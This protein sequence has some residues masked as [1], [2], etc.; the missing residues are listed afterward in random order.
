MSSIIL[1]GCLGSTFFLSWGSHFVLL[2]FF[3]YI[4]IKSPGITTALSHTESQK[5]ENRWYNFTPVLCRI[6]FCL[7][8]EQN[9]TERVLKVYPWHKLLCITNNIWLT[10]KS[11]ILSM[12]SHFFSQFVKILSINYLNLKYEEK[13]SIIRCTVPPQ[14]K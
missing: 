1:K 8:L 5:E 7:F 9:K 10:T 13:C 11:H 12:L 6:Y 3:N 14:N 4:I 2:G